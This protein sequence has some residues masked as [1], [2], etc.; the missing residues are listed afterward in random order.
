[1]VA[2]PFAKPQDGIIS[3][4]DVQ[5]ARPRA[6]ERLR[7]GSSSSATLPAMAI[8]SI[9]KDVLDRKE[10]C[11]AIALAAKRARFFDHNLGHLG[12]F[13]RPQS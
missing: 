9:F 3:A 12:S 5:S 10:N 7:G 13:N 8:E 6:G 11:A 4:Y 2:A 1:V